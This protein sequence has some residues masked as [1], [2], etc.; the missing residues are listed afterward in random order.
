ML[1]V[2]FWVC[3]GVSLRYVC[4]LLGYLKRCFCKLVVE[5]GSLGKG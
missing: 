1:T 2:L 5:F 4:T 3:D